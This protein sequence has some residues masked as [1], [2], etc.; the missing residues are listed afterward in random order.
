MAQV[1]YQDTKTPLPLRTLMLARP[2]FASSPCPTVCLARYGLSFALIYA[3]ENPE[4]EYQQPVHATLSV[5]AGEDP[6]PG[7]SMEGN[8]CFWMKN[9]SENEGLLEQL[10][11]AGWLRDSGRKIK[12]G[13]VT[14]PMVE[15][16]LDESEIAKQCPNCEVFEQANHHERFKRCSKCKKAFYCSSKCQQEDYPIHKRICK[17][18]AAG[19]FAEVENRK[20]REVASWFDGSAS[21]SS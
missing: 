9:Y 13:Y 20:R 11:Q 10:L 19:R 14:L 3:Q 5:M 21:T 18:L 7:F 17:D 6:F 16:R 12:Q 8:E 1:V 4:D 15:I 2:A